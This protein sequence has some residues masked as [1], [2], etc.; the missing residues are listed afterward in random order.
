MERGV[1]SRDKQGLEAWAKVL[2]VSKG[3]ASRS[4]IVSLLVAGYMGVYIASTILRDDP[5]GRQYMK[6]TDY[7]SMVGLMKY[8]SNGLWGEGLCLL[9]VSCTFVV[10]A[11]TRL[12]TEISDLY[13][14]V[15]TSGRHC[16][17]V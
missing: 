6:I 3:N 16:N 9:Q 1:I 14:L 5:I 11:T 2:I 12:I 10:D 17:G 7:D 15:V 8:A 13:I 4:W